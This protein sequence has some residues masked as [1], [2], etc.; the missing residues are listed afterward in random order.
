MKRPSEVGY[1]NTSFMKTLTP[2][3][4]KMC[5]EVRTI[6]LTKEE[7]DYYNSIKPST[8]PIAIPFEYNHKVRL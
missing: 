2:P 6:N 5:S 7:W 1:Y 4:D 3:E 8:E